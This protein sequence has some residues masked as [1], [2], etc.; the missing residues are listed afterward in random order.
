MNVPML[1]SLIIIGKINLFNLIFKI[2]AFCKFCDVLR[3][4]NGHNRE[5]SED[6]HLVEVFKGLRQSSFCL[7]KHANRPG[8]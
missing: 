2:R 8:R 1:S 7:W 4:L 6:W 3:C 5:A